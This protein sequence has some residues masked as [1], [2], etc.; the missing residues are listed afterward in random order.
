MTRATGVAR[1]RWTRV[2][3]ARFAA[4]LTVAAALCSVGAAA[5]HA[6]V[7]APHLEASVPTGALFL[8]A[9]LGQA[10]W[11][12]LVLVRPSGRLLLAGVA[13]N[14]AILAGWGLSRTAGL[15][16]GPD[17]WIPE[18]VTALDA[19]ASALELVV[20]A[21]CLVLARERTYRPPQGV[22]GFA[23]I[24][25]AAIAGTIGAAFIATPSSADEDPPPGRPT[26][27]SHA[28]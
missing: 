2:A 23:A 21:V 13:G 20:V 26:A 24:C 25:A 11:A 28:H 12:A 22:R 3:V 9:A 16:I 6:A 17:A 18:R 4:E 15:P 7:T 14:L 10:V 8:L 5:I 19:T 1:A 27:Q